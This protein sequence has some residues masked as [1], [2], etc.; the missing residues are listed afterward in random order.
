MMAEYVALSQAM[1]DM[2]PLKRLVKEI[3]QV[4][5]GEEEVK[6]V[7]KS[8]VWEDNNGALTVATMPR[9]TPQSKFFAVKYHFFREHVKTDDNPKGE[10]HIQ[11][12]DTKRQ[13]GDIMTKGLVEALFIPLRDR[14]MGWVEDLDEHAYRKSIGESSDGTN[15][16]ESSSRGS[17]DEYANAEQSSQGNSRSS[18]GNSRSSQ[19]NS[20]NK[21]GDHGQNKNEDPLE[22]PY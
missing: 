11:K 19:G 5:T 14:L 18:Q 8:D 4:V 9:I 3:A 20:Q 22:V 21:S 2:L 12:I 15:S 16:A 1:R 7:M 13:L 6:V 10:V 17:V